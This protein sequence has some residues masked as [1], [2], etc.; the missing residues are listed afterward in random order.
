MEI[1]MK[2]TIR[3]LEMRIARLEKTSSAKRHHE[4]MMAKFRMPRLDRD[5]YTDLSYQGLE[6]PFMFK[7]GEVLYYDPK[8]GKYYD[9]D[10]DMY[11]SDRDADRITSGYR[12]ASL[13]QAGTGLK[14]V[15]AMLPG[16][17]DRQANHFLHALSASIID[18]DVIN[19]NEKLI[20]GDIEVDSNSMLHPSSPSYPILDTVEGIVGSK[21]KMK[22]KVDLKD[23]QKLAKMNLDNFYPP[24]DNSTKLLCDA[25]TKNIEN[26]ILRNMDSEEID[27]VFGESQYEIEMKLPNYHNISQIE[28]IEY[29]YEVKDIFRENE[30]YLTVIVIAQIEYDVVAEFDRDAMESDKY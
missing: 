27:L 28:V 1:K 11:L 7:G 29:D 17:S 22:L 16:V 2:D 8:A 15:Q 14:S 30:R 18:S 24:E 10:T 25:L 13:K 3:S 19:K 12:S 5:R 23:L 4:E 26:N 9:R 20:K 6:G 21:T